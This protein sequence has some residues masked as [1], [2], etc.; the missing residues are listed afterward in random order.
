VAA[1]AL[2]T[3]GAVLLAD[4]DDPDPT[5]PAT[6]PVT[7]PPATVPPTTAPPETV[8]PGRPAALV[9]AC[10][11][12]P[13][14]GEAPLR[15]DF[16][17]FP[18]GGTGT[19]EFL[20]TFGDGGTS[21]NPNPGHTFLT[22]G[23]FDSTVR[24]TSGD[25]VAGCSRAITVKPPPAPGPSPSTSPSPA[26]FKLRASLAG[27]GLGKV[28]SAPPGID[29]PGDCDEFYAPGTVVTL[30]AVPSPPSVFKQWSG[31]CTGIT[32][33]CVLTM[34]TDK[35]VTAHFELPRTLTVTAGTNSDVSG[36]VS[37][38]PAGITC[39]WVPNQ[40]CT[41]TA[42]YING[43]TVTLTVV[44]G[45]GGTRVDWGGDCAAATGT[46]CTILMDADKTVTVD[47]F[48]LF[49]VQGAEEEATGTPLAWSTQLE[50]AEGEGQVVINGRV[51]SAVRPGIAALTAEA[52]AG[53]NR[54]EAVLVSGA[55]RHGT[56]RF[57]FGGSAVFRPG[58]LRVVAGTIVLVTGEAVV[59]RLQGRPGE[60]VVFTFEVDR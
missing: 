33:T 32:P 3:T 31:D 37:S 7:N 10:Q 58:S 55:G 60:R 51:S 48:R 26:T 47:T 57:D 35:T 6:V 1:A 38:N 25:Q 46:T 50:V 59:F 22:P 44:L 36:S 16:A 53:A 49:N 18:N 39:A 8:P 12:S 23:V 45:P 14:D 11:A 40:P 43:T 41:D 15:V 5:T 24:V 52:R 17:T 56:W 21:P 13:R 2:A 9:V 29:C 34:T 28:T 54:V 19:Y 42:T 20:W 27:S 4:D 30:T